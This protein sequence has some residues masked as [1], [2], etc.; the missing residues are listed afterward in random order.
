[1]CIKKLR[2]RKRSFRRCMKKLRRRALRFFALHLQQ[3]FAKIDSDRACIDEL[4][5]QAERIQTNTFEHT[6]YTSTCEVCIQP[7]VC[8]N[9]VCEVITQY[10]FDVN[11][12]YR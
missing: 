7:M 6:I 12:G 5:A 1:L 3:I 10:F 4:F 2:W 11:V 8:I 9:C